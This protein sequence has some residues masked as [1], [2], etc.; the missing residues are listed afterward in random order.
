MICAFIIATIEDG[1]YEKGGRK[2]RQMNE[3]ISDEKLKEAL[4]KLTIFINESLSDA[5]SLLLEKEISN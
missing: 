3:E 4:E 1:L 2:K 5:R